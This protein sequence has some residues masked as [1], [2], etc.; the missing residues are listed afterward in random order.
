MW[1]WVLIAVCV[2]F[3]GLAVVGSTVFVV[4]N[5]RVFWGFDK[6]N[7]VATELEGW[8]DDG[9]DLNVII[10]ELGDQAVA[11]DG[12]DVRAMEAVLKKLMAES[13]KAPE[14]GRV[15]E[16]IIDSEDVWAQVQYDEYVDPVTWAWTRKVAAKEEVADEEVEAVFDC[17][18]ASAWN[19][20][21]GVGKRIVGLANDGFAKD[22]DRWWGLFEQL[23]P[24][25][26]TFENMMAEFTREL[27]P[28]NAGRA[29]LYRANGLKL[30]EGWDGAHPFDTADG[31]ARLK[32]WLSTGDDSSFTAAVALAFVSDKIRAEL[33][34]FGLE[35]PIPDVQ[36][37]AAWAELKGATDNPDPA[38]LARLVKGCL[39]LAE[40]RTSIDYLEETG[41]DD[42]VPEAAREP[43]FAAK[44]EMVDWLTHPNELGGMPL[45]ISEYDTRTLVW[46]PEAEEGIMPD[47]APVYLF[48]FTYPE[49]DTTATG[50]GIVSDG[51]AWSSFTRYDSPP[52]A[53]TLYAEQ[54]ALELTWNLEDDDAPDVTREEALKILKLHKAERVMSEL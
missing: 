43:S 31:A 30:D 35:H 5:P 51:W 44:A 42:S 48:E 13:G 54:C 15:A 10:D 23:V 38:A 53:E 9:G 34:P 37:E 29:L 1:A 24:E 14:I 16:L 17:L 47:P 39:D 19:Y 7:P 18:E 11:D 32:K 26:T 2:G 21:E 27:P 52:S 50:Y 36:L 28:G 25:E 4:K 49:E 8:L 6:G 41:Y 46:P 40:S 33:L 20:T 3:F 22:S 12:R 45:S